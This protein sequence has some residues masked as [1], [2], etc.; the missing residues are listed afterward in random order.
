MKTAAVKSTTAAMEPAAVAAAS[1]L[2][3]CR[4]YRQATNNQEPR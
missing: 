3:C 2:S 4:Q 1:A